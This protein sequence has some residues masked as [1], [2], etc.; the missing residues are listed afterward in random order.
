M[1][2]TWCGDITA[3][4]YHRRRREARMERRRLAGG[5]PASRW[6]A[7][8]RRTAN[9]TLVL[10]SRDLLL[11]ELRAPKHRRDVLRESLRREVQ[12]HAGQQRLALAQPVV[13]SV[14]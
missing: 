6:P 12:P 8:R 4:E 11:G 5:P 10:H 9:E 14:D 2:L 13:A 3:R 7:R 1:V